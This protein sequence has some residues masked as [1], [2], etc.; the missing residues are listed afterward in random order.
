M[1]DKF[2]GAYL[3]ILINLRSHF[4]ESLRNIEMFIGFHLATCLRYSVTIHP[5]APMKI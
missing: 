4:R 2:G 5:L 3:T 1:R